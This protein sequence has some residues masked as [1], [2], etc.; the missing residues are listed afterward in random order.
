M[1]PLSVSSRGGSRPLNRAPPPPQRALCPSLCA[2]RAMPRPAPLPRPP[3]AAPNLWGDHRRLVLERFDVLKIQGID[4]VTESFTAACFVVLRF[5]GGAADPVLSANDPDGSRERSAR[6]YASK[7]ESYNHYEH[8]S[9]HGPLEPTVKEVD[10]GD[11]TLQMR[12][13]GRFLVAM[14]LREFPF[15]VQSLKLEFL[16]TCRVEDLQLEVAHNVISS[17]V[18]RGFHPTRLWRVRGKPE[19]KVDVHDA[20]GRSFPTFSMTQQVTRQPEYYLANVALPI[21]VISGLA[22]TAFSIPPAEVA[23]RLGVVL[24][25]LLSLTTYK[26]AVTEMIPQVPYQTHL[27]RYVLLNFLLLAAVALT[28][29]LLPRFGMGG[30]GGGGGSVAV[31]TPW[32]ACA[33]LSSFV[34]GAASS[35]GATGG[36]FG[37]GGDTM[38]GEGGRAR[39]QRAQLPDVLDD[40]T[41]DEATGVLPDQ[42]CPPYRRHLRPCLH[43]LLNSTCRGRRPFRRGTNP[44]TLPHDIQGR[45]D[46]DDPC[47]ASPVGSIRGRALRIISSA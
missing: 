15:D 39:C 21:A 42:R 12:F 35:C 34:C 32:T 26:F 4:S 19:V 47:C 38:D 23:D 41:G 9:C 18:P 7:I 37:G 22:F 20:N 10:G 33:L 36:G 30:G 28:V 46:L 29:G 2:R 11:L 24:T 14:D 31:A 40:A 1:A 44:T 5:P 17:T 45:G 6:W 8:G 13:E 25:L 3:P 27:D 16:V 43:R